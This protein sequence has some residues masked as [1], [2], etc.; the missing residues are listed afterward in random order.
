MNTENALTM[1]GLSEKEAKSY[2]ACLKLGMS[3]TQD[4]ARETRLPR[5]TIYSILDSLIKQGLVT[6]INQGKIVKFSARD[7]QEIITKSKEKQRAIEKVAPQLK[8][9]YK[10]TDHRPKIK[11]YEGY[12]E[13]ERL[14]NEILS[15]PHLKSYDVLSSTSQFLKFS[16]AKSFLDKRAE[17]NIKIRLIATNSPE[18]RT[19]KKTDKEYG[20]DIKIVPEKL[21]K[22]LSSFLY[23]FNKRVI[24]FGAHDMIAVS[25]ESKEIREPLKVM[26]DILWNSQMDISE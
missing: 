3:S 19:Y 21:F 20:I 14:H 12:E 16:F 8:E 18:I 2:L 1:Y 25:I 9:L 10:T 4:I 5:T 22:N 11:Y 15:M 13:L 26:Y 6:K 23:I 7:P 17:K 24:F